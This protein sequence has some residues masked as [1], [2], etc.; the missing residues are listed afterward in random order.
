MIKKQ[1]FKKFT[2]KIG[3]IGFEPI[4]SAPKALILPLNYTLKNF[5]KLKLKTV[6][7]LEPTFL[8]LQT[9]TLPLCYTD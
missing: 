8:V 1:I 3:A 5:Y 4:T 9:T 7:G 2:K 6:V